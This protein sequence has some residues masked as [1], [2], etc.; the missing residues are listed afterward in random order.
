ME[1]I[2]GAALVVGLVMPLEMEPHTTMLGVGPF[3]VLE[4]K[5]HATTIY[6]RSMY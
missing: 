6:Y 1:S 5:D 2:M 4:E 3:G